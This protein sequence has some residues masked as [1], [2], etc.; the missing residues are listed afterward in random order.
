MRLT[1]VSSPPITILLDGAVIPYYINCEYLPLPATINIRRILYV[2]GG[3]PMRNTQIA[4]A[5]PFDE[6]KPQIHSPSVVGASPAKPFLYRIPATG[7]PP[8]TFSCLTALPEELSL[9]AETGIVTGTAPKKAGEY[10]LLL[11]VGNPLGS[12]EKAVCLRIAPD[13]ACITPLLGWTSWNAFRNGITQEK[14]S[15]A[16]DLLARTGL[17]QYGYQYVNIDSGWQGEYGGTLDAIQ[18]KAEFPD[19]KSLADH[20]HNL[21]LKLGIY[22]TPMQKAWGGGEYPGCTRGKIDSTYMD[23]Y[24]G[25]GS[26]HREDANAAQWDEWGLDY[27]KYDW[28]PCDVKN[29]SL[30]KNCLLRRR[31]DFAFCVTVHAGIENADYWKTNCSSWRDNTDSEDTWPSV[32]SRFA[33]DHWAAHCNPGHYF[34]LDMLETGVIDQHACRLTEDEQLV[35]YSI[36]ALFP[37]PIQLSC[38]LSKLTDF[39]LA[40]LCNDEILAVNQDRL[41]IGAVCLSERQTHDLSRSETGCAKIYARPLEDGSFAAG[42]FNLGETSEELTL[43]LKGDAAIR[44]LWARKPLGVVSGSLALSLAAHSCRMLKISGGIR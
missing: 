21:G 30:M 8:L 9:D 1:H 16:A 29:A 7:K 42:F 20:V 12:A 31:R 6:G 39:D 33:F 5:E 36:R 14:I 32:K 11:R 18:P 3:L 27:L 2:W 38:D 17:A 43:G 37:S 35:S 4:P 25:I 13:G 34:D 41:G 44:D 24:F 10:P 26:E 23:A 40:M 15:G 19:M 22:S 28:T